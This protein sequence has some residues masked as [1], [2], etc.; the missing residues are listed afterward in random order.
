[1]VVLLCLEHCSI[2]GDKQNL[3]SNQPRPSRN[4]K[5]VVALLSHHCQLQRQL[6]ALV[7]DRWLMW[8][9]AHQSS[10]HNPSPVVPSLMDLPIVDRS[11]RNNG[12][13][14]PLMC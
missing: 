11:F 13:L 3:T 5:I 7:N 12:P 14:Q 1:M 4:C 6:S 9:G 10:M 8:Q 2:V